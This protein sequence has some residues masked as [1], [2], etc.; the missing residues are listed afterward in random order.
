MFL[1]R[2]IKKWPRGRLDATLLVPNSGVPINRLADT[3]AL[4]AYISA[5]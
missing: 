1:Q 3:K 2:G 5:I 4:G